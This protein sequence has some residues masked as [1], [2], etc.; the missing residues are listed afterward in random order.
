MT[1]GDLN[2]TQY[3]C[4]IAD[5]FTSVKPNEICGDVLSLQCSSLFLKMLYLKCLQHFNLLGLTGLKSMHAL[6]LVQ[7]KKVRLISTVKEQVKAC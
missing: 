4:R 5:K 7:K 2:T 6:K 1:S 3:Y